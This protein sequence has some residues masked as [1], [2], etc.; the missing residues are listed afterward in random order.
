[1]M[2]QVASVEKRC[3]E[4]E[5]RLRDLNEDLRVKKTSLATKEGKL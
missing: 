4:K 5:Q 3:V 1:M 2:L